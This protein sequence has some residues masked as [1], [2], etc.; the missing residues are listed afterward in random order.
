MGN[1]QQNPQI[2]SAN[3]ITADAPS[4][5]HFHFHKHFVFPMT[6][7][8]AT[9]IC[10]N[11]PNA[12]K[13]RV[14]TARF[15]N[16]KNLKK[17]PTKPANNIPIPRDSFPRTFSPAFLYYTYF[18]TILSPCHIYLVLTS[19]SLPCGNPHYFSYRNSFSRNLGIEQAKISLSPK[20]AFAGYKREKKEVCEKE[21]SE[22]GKNACRKERGG[23]Q[24]IR[25]SLLPA[26]RA[27][28]T[29]ERT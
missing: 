28:K 18:L 14:F 11:P 3:N 15:H 23:R 6:K 27:A 16:E 10:T 19:P 13:R 22:M 17:S 12:Q 2:K 20:A 29:R 24:K 9:D 5:T 21:K 1:R 7:G 4:R 8:N 25:R 26:E